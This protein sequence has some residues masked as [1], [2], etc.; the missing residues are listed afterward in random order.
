MICSVWFQAGQ[1]YI[2]GTRTAYW[3]LDRS[4]LI[5]VATGFNLDQF[6]IRDIIQD[7][8][9]AEAGLQ[10]GDVIVRL[11]GLRGSSYT[12]DQITSIMQKKVGKRIKIVVDRNGERIKCRFELRKL[13]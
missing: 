8:P 13:I 3:A 4:G 2:K 6:V 7:S 10:P 9:A 11:Q 12:L 5:I 1:I